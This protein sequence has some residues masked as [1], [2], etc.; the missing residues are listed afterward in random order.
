M[1]R[2]KYA[3]TIVIQRYRLY[4]NSLNNCEKTQKFAV[5]RNNIDPSKLFN[6]Y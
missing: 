5:Y 3:K 6:S 2:V 1:N 4:V